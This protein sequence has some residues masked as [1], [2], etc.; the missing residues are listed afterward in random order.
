M[1]EPTL[2]ILMRTDLESMNPGKGMA[3]AAHAANQF[4]S[5]YAD[6]QPVATWECEADGFGT[7]IVLDGGSERK[8]TD[9]VDNC[10]DQGFIADIVID[11]TY[12]V[13]D[14]TYPVIDG[15]V[16]HQLRLIT[17]AFVFTPCR[18]EKPVTP[19]ERFFLHP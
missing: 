4:V 7:T 3:Q 12:P 11:P 15:E 8:I 6:T 13:I 1:S 16:V 17:C 5:N 10:I 19:L 14:P 18:I 2:Y 9:T